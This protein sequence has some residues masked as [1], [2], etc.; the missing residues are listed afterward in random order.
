MRRRELLQAAALSVLPGALVASDAPAGA[1]PKTF[2]WAFV[3]AETGFDPAQVQ[4]LY[5][6]TVIGHILDAPLE[7]DYMARPARLR[8][9]TLVAMPDV[10]A[11]LRTFTFRLRPG[12]LF[13]DDA[14]FGGQPRELV[15]AD[16]VYSWKRLLDPRMRSPFAWYLQ[17]KIVG[18]DAVIAAANRS[19]KF[20]YDAPTKG[21][22]ALDRYTFQVLYHPEAAAGPH[23]AEYLFDKFA[24]L[25]A[26]EK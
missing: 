15:A 3:A 12:I 4:D 11:D 20:D 25:M 22:R 6:R 7:F 26:G 21:L 18:A 16:Y 10:S 5:S 9:S 13:Q 19:G 2:R 17:G 24:D 14:A 8:V 23:D 1:R